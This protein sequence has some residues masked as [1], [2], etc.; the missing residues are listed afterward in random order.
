[1]REEK[2]RKREVS[3]N[4]RITKNVLKERETQKKKKVEKG[5][6]EESE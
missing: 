4:K 5:E 2:R 6:R 1:M 3:E